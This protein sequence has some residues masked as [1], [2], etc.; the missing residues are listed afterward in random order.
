ML[1][2]VLLLA[3]CERSSTQQLSREEVARRAAEL[4]A[5]RARRKAEL[6]A[7]RRRADGGTPAVRPIGDFGWPGLRPDDFAE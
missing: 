5:A 2:A 3:A 4:E 6:D 7:Q 1:L